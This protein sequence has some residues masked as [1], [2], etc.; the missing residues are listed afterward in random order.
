MRRIVQETV[1]FIINIAFR[2][3]EIIYNY[4]KKSV[5]CIKD[6]YAS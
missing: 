1:F 3:T 6:S 5:F 2:Y 4:K